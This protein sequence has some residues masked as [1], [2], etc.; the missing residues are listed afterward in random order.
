[1]DRFDDFDDDFDPAIISD[2]IS[3]NRRYVEPV[4]LDRVMGPDPVS[5]NTNCVVAN[6]TDRP[7]TASKDSSNLDPKPASQRTMA[8][9]RASTI[10]AVRTKE[11]D[12]QI[13]DYSGDDEP[14]FLPRL[15]TV[16]Q[17]AKY[18]AISIS[19]VWRLEKA[20]VG[21]PKALRIAGSTRWDRCAIDRF[22]DSFLTPALGGR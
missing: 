4:S 6:E 3:G 10:P 20:N 12:P 2:L 21:F 9:K 16:K 5:T 18:L 13:G 14:R 7:A 11:A 8:H 19:K 22:L 1:M 17:V 15:M